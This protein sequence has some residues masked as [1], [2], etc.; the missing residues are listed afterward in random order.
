M[1]GNCGH[2]AWTELVGRKNPEVE[3]K[4]AM[5][6]DNTKSQRE[7]VYVC[8]YVRL[9]GVSVG[10]YVCMYVCTV[11]QSGTDRIQLTYSLTN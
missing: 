6:L 1:V 3:L 5:V 11:S 9:C 8:M 10:M 4:W 2:V 7:R